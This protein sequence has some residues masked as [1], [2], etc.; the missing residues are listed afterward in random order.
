MHRITAIGKLDE[1]IDLNLGEH[2]CSPLF[3]QWEVVH[4]Q[5]IFRPHIAA[6]DA[7]STQ[8]A[9][10]LVHTDVV[11]LV[12]IAAKVD[13]DVDLGIACPACTGRLPVGF[14]LAQRV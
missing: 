12:S 9:E 5:G 6:G 1:V 13:G 4:I 3:R 11:R 10:L 14:E 8:G 2:L 7:I